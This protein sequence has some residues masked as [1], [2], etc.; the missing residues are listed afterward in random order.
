MAPATSTTANRTTRSNSLKASSAP[1]DTSPSTACAASGKAPP[2]TLATPSDVATGGYPGK[3]AEAGKVPMGLHFKKGATNTYTGTTVPKQQAPT[4]TSISSRT[5]N[6]FTPLAAL[7]EDIPDEDDELTEYTLDE[8]IARDLI[9]ADDMEATIA[10]A[11]AMEVT[12]PADEL[13]IQPSAGS[14]RDPLAAALASTTEEASVTQ[15]KA[16][17][18]GKEK[19]PSSG[20]A[21]APDAAKQLARK[22]AGLPSTPVPI[23]TSTSSTSGGTV[24]WSAAVVAAAAVP[25]TAAAATSP[26]LS[27]V[28]TATSTTTNANATATTAPSAPPAQ[29]A[30]SSIVQV[31]PASTNQVAPASVTR[32]GAASLVQVAPAPATTQAAPARPA[33]SKAGANAAPTAS[34][35]AASTTSVSVPPAT[36]SFATI[37]AAAPAAPLTRSTTRKA[38]AAAAAATATAA[39]TSTTPTPT[40]TTTASSHPPTLTSAPTPPAPAA[41]LPGPTHTAVTIAPTAA[42]AAPI[43]QQAGAAAIH[44][45]APAAA[46]LAAPVA[47]PQQPAGLIA[48]AIHLVGAA[49]AGLAGHQAAA[50]VQCTPPPP[51]GFPPIYGWT[52]KGFRANVT[53]RQLSG[54]NIMAGPKVIV[55]EFGGSHYKS[56]SPP[57]NFIERAKN[58]VAQHFSCPAPL[59]GPMEAESIPTVHAAPFTYVLAGI[60]Q[61]HMQT[62]IN[63]IVWSFPTVTLFAFPYPAEISPFL[64]TIDG[65]F[66]GPNDTVTVANLVATTYRDDP[67][68]QAFLARCHDNYPAGVNPMD[69]FI[70]SIRVSPQELTN[71]SGQGVR[72][73][74]NVTAQ[75]PSTN[76]DHHEEWLTLGLKLDFFSVSYGVGKP[77]DPPL[78]C[79]KCKSL[80][81]P[82][83]RC[84]LE[85]V[86]GF[87]T[88][89]LAN[90]T[91]AATTSGATGQTRGRGGNRGRARGG[92]TGRARA[93]GTPRGRGF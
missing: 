81:H 64:F 73:A 27:P 67:N 50:G 51:G 74:W 68:A 54:M 19:A 76:D 92:S 31:A 72:T 8:Q 63:Q 83:G 40:T 55:Y 30:K 37:A 18:K 6:S 14:M 87:H 42:G 43:Q 12:S 38:Q 21:K 90:A 35:T 25:A 16:S 82:E 56:T 49:P 10:A 47:P 9:G 15:G 29:P 48:P 62:M 32:V 36:T 3:P 4:S 26:F 86:A 1:A 41:A 45:P 84:L 7:N 11:F 69:H 75:P 59:I 22:L 52:P 39:S 66:Y 23:P 91:P 33:P 24:P 89:T 78:A 2:P 13:H 46:V 5:S 57:S 65:M 44:A 58:A 61:Q 53:G 85:S 17:K 88:T 80:G 93:R 60:P 77:L 70:L 20:P 34:G 79:F 71:P 28:T